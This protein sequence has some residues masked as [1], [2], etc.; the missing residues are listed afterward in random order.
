M[1]DFGGRRV[2]VYHVPEAMSP[3]AVYVDADHA[4]WNRDSLQ[5]DNGDWIKD[6]QYHTAEGSTR[7]MDTPMQ[8]L[9]RWYGFA[10]TFPDCDVVG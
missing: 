6:N 5:F 3:V 7:P 2:L 4:T 8:L 9:M 10:S 1:T